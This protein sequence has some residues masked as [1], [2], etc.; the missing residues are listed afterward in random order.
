MRKIRFFLAVLLIFVSAVPALASWAA[1]EPFEVFSEDGT[2][3]FV[4]TPGA[5]GTGSAHAAVYTINGAAPNQERQVVYT[6]VDLSS[7]AYE[8]NFY[9]SSDMNHFARMFNPS[10]SPIFEVFSNGI[11][12]RTVFRNDIIE[13]H[14]STE[15]ETSIG[16]RYTVN[17]TIESFSPEEAILTISTGEDNTFLFDLARAEFVAERT[18][19]N[20]YEDTTEPLNDLPAESPSEARQTPTSSILTWIIAAIS[21]IIGIF[22]I[23]IVLLRRRK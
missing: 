9:F 13:N 16:P 5:Y 10:G 6:V 11:R 20:D 7:F 14:S 1:P 19:S 21:L 17:W 12:T 23:V 22:I 4:F 18:L 2:R 3:V 8:S 15:A